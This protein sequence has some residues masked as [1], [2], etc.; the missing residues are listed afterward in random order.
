[1]P[2]YLAYPGCCPELRLVSGL[3]DAE[4]LF[5]QGRGSRR[6]FS[7]KHA[8]VQD[9]AYNSLVRKKREQ[10]HLAVADAL[11]E[12]FEETCFKEPEVVAWHLQSAGEFDRSLKYWE[13]A[14]ERSLNSYAYQEAIEQI[15]H[16]LDALEQLP[17]SHDNVKDPYPIIVYLQGSYGVGGPIENVNKWGLTRLIRDENDL[18]NE[19]N[20]LLTARKPEKWN[21]SW[22]PKTILILV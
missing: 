18:S 9:A 2:F 3:V 7:F 17:E 1:M 15:Q 14:S 12:N 8:L 21:C 10:L 11:E 20:Q 4:V 16:A 6:R 22:D 19:R 5:C 13:N